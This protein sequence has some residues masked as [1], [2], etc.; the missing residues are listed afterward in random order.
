MSGSHHP[1]PLFKVTLV[2]SALSELDMEDNAGEEGVTLGI[3]LTEVISLLSPSG[4]VIS[5]SLKIIKITESFQ[6]WSG[7]ILESWI[8]YHTTRY[9]VTTCSLPPAP[10]GT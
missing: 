4:P 8:Q 2:L 9:T 6:E 5:L 10:A 3:Q 7:S 1:N